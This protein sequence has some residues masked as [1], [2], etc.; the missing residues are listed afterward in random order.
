MENPEQTRRIVA[1]E[2]E[3]TELQN[4]LSEQQSAGKKALADLEAAKKEAETKSR[5]LEDKIKAMESEKSVLENSLEALQKEFEEYKNKY[6]VSAREKARG[7]FVGKVQTL[8]G[9]VYEDAA[10]GRVDAASVH[11]NHKS[12]VARLALTD[13]DESWR[14]RFDYV[15]PMKRSLSSW[16]G[17]SR[18]S[19]IREDARM[20][21]PRITVLIPCGG[22]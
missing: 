20:W 19:A 15:I 12:G 11:I 8:E 22:T 4:N 1:L 3:M 14:R 13:L 7:E 16:L 17:K 2:A 18:D 9:K 5:V 6:R 10:I 21:S